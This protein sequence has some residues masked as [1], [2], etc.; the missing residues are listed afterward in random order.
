MLLHGVRTAS[1][2][3]SLLDCRLS[4][5]QALGRN[6][7]CVR[8]STLRCS[9]GQLLSSGSCAKTCKGQRGYFTC[10]ESQGWRCAC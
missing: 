1:T 2:Q 4:G 8:D 6:A 9:D 10:P 7:R 5:L 3:F